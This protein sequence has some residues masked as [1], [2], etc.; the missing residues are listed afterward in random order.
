[1]QQVV[2]GKVIV[3]SNGRIQFRAPELLE[4]TTAE[5]LVIVTADKRRVPKRESSEL[6]ESISAYA[7]KH[8]G[9]EVDLDLELEGAAVEFLAND[10]KGK[11]R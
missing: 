8:A 6:H 4:G 3:K 1:M 11:R 5:V 7:A 9:S 10:R 2:R